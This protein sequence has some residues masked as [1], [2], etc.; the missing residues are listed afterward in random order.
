MEKQRFE[1]KS[2]SC[3]RLLTILLISL[4]FTNQIFA[5]FLSASEINSLRIKPSEGQSLYT[6]TDLKFEVVIPKVKA[7]QIQFLS[8]SQRSDITFRTMRK[9][10]DYENGGTLIEIWYNFEKK[11]TYTLNPIQLSIQGRRRNIRFEQITVTDDP[12][13]QT[14]R[15]VI[16]FNNGTTVYSDNGTYNAPLFSAQAGK[17]I[18]LTVYLQYATQMMNFNWDIPK[19]A[20][21]SQTKS[22]EIMEVKYREKNITHDLIPVASFEWT[23]LAKGNQ[24]LPRMKITATAYNGTR[25]ELIMPELSAT[26]T[27]ASTQNS[28]S[29]DDKMFD[30]AFSQT[31]LEAEIKDSILIT[32]ELCQDLADMYSKERNSLF[33]TREMKKTRRQFELEKN[34]PVNYERDYSVRLI[35]GA[36]LLL[37]GGIILLILAIHEKKSFRIMIAAVVLTFAL[38]SLVYGIFKRLETQAICTGCTIYSIPEENAEAKAE[39]GAGNKVRITEKAGKWYYIELGE[40]GGWCRAENVIIIK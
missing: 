39:M 15:I 26:F 2:K 9:T 12:A 17:K 23:S 38:V 13:K 10:E 25:Y 4:F 35:F 27:A 34:L 16:K 31:A 6:K 5:Q 33:Y 11:G 3:R 32:K 22:Y 21:F 37:V 7:S 28:S 8:N 20:I 30:S 29:K 14:P 18:P 36:L 1:P 40:S 19:D 24:I